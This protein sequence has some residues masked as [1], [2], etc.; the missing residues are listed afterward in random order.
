MFD[1]NYMGNGAAEASYASENAGHFALY[2]TRVAQESFDIVEDRRKIVS[3]DQHVPAYHTEINTKE[4]ND[5]GWFQNRFRTNISSARA[6]RREC[7][8]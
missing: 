4:M 7:K 6:S 5:L 8:T 1:Q 2:W 3:R